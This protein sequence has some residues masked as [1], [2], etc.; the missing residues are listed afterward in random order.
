MR[1]KNSLFVEELPCT[2][3]QHIKATFGNPLAKSQREQC[4]TECSPESVGGTQSPS[5][6]R[7][8]KGRRCLKEPVREVLLLEEPSKLS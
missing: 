6:A 5:A 7:T 2:V 4:Q 1:N 3:F 8:A